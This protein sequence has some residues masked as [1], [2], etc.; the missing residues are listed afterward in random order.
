MSNIRVIKMGVEAFKIPEQVRPCYALSSNGQKPNLVIISHRCK[1][2]FVDQPVEISIKTPL[3][4]L[5][6]EI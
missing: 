4:G 5:L 1:A 6:C 2:D 3:F